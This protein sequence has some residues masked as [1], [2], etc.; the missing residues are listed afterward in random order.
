MTHV[1]LLRDRRLGLVKPS[2]PSNNEAV[3]VLCVYG[4]GFNYG[5]P[6]NTC[7]ALHS[8][9][10]ISTLLKQS[11]SEP[12]DNSDCLGHLPLTVGLLLSRHTYITAAMII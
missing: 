12:S 11:Y 2:L 7:F 9:T 6:G 10:C 3:R 8:I 5:P 1:P 4:K